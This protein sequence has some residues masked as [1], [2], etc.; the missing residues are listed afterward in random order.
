MIR[1]NVHELDFRL[2][3][4]NHLRSWIHGLCKEKNKDIV[5]LDYVFCSDD[6][7]LGINKEHLQHDYFTDIITFDYTTNA[8]EI[9]AEL[10]LSIDRIRENASEIGVSFADELH[11]VMIHG[12]LHLLGNGDKT[13]AESERMRQLENEALTARTFHVKQYTERRKKQQP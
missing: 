13:P 7:L 2:L 10:Y 3:D 8:S 6:Y 12:V 9:S 4:Q 1:Y 11:R 5:S